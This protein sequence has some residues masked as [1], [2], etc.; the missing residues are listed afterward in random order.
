M[1]A[2][3]IIPNPECSVCLGTG[4]CTCELWDNDAH[5]MQ[6]TGTE[7]CECSIKNRKEYLDGDYN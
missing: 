4:Y 3:S 2:N 7:E 1:P 5:I 6:P